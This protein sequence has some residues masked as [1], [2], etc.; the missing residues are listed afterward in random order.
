MEIEAI[1]RDRTIGQKKLM[2]QCKFFLELFGISEDDLISV[3]YSDML[4]GTKSGI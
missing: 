4:L 2:E 3:S 1:D